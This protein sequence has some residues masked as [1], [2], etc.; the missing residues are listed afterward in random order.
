[1]FFIEKPLRF[2]GM[3]GSAV[4]GA[5]V[6]LLIVL[7]IQRAGGQALAGRPLMVLGVML[8]VLGFQSIALGLIGEIVVHLHAPSRRPYRL[9]EQEPRAAVAMRSSA[10]GG[11]LGPD[12]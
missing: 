1:L 12:A 8:V 7:V 10:E 6:L 4:S 11:Q 2:F 9:A 5:G 3:V